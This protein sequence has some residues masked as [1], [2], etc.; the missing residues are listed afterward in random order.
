MESLAVRCKSCSTVLKVRIDK[1]GQK[2]RCKHC[3]AAAA[4]PAH[5]VEPIPEESR[6]SAPAPQRRRVRRQP[7]PERL[8]FLRSAPGWRKVRIGLILLA[9]S[10]C[11]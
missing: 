1:A 3:S 4:V 5:E 6:D 8:N 11:T 7:D 10:M 9:L 2:V